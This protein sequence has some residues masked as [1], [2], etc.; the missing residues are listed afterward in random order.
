ME[1]IE[2]EW[3]KREGQDM[4]TKVHVNVS[5]FLLPATNG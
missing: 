4:T 5:P 1:T 3:E 2:R